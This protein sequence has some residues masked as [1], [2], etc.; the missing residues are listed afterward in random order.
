[1][2]EKEKWNRLSIVKEEGTGDRRME[3]NSLL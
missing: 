2:E 3:S 1:M